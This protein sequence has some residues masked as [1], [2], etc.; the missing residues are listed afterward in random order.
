MANP[1]FELESFEP[2]F[3][4]RIEKRIYKKLS[5]YFKHEEFYKKPFSV[6][7]SLSNKS[8][9]YFY[10]VENKKQTK[11]AILVITIANGCRVGGCDVEHQ[12]GEEFE[13]FYL[14]TLYNDYGELVDI[15]ILDYQSEHGYQ[16]SSAWWLKQFVNNWD[17]KF[18]YGKNI[19]AISGATISVKSTIRELSLLQKIINNQ[20]YQAN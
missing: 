13:Q 20:L 14:Y 1:S 17:K 12:E 3:S 10:F 7:D 18:I 2:N 5:K 16:I 19:D 4:K 11:K 6:H 9:S 15:R 8:N